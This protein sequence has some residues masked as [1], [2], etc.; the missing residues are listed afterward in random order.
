MKNPHWNYYRSLVE[1]LDRLARY[2]EFSRDNFRTYSIEMVRLLLAAGS[3]V[4]VVAKLLCDKAAPSSLRRNILDYQKI[5]LPKYPDI[6][7]IVVSMPRYSLEF[8]PWQGW[9]NES[10]AWW[11]SYNQVKHTRND[12]YSEACLGNVLYSLSGLCVLVSYLE[13]E[14]FSKEAVTRRPSLF[15]DSKYNGEG[16]ILFAPCI[17]LP[18]IGIQEEN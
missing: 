17:K 14:F 12:H 15:L 4:D 5:V 9:E 13:Y 11:T 8:I 3:E 7:S 16:K 2:V 10:P 1:D 18:G 6:C